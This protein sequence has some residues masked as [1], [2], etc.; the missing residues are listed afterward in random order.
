MI[1]AI[2]TRTRALG[3]GGDLLWHIPEDM[4]RFKTLTMGHPVIMGRKTWESIPEKF[5]PLPGRTNIVITRTEGYE[6]SGA[7]IV[8][9]FASAL[10]RAY[11]E[12]PNEI[13]VIGG[14]QIY[15]EG[16]PYTQRLYLSLIDSDEEGDIF[17]PEYS[18]FTKEISR[19]EHPESTPPYTFVVLEK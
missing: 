13:F 7:V 12:T 1:A 17:F 15:T 2:G 14:S 9:D 6:A 3:K 18:E 10:K 5:R 8:H 19:E 4:K 16:L 11:E